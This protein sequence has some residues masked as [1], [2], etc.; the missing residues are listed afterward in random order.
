V[1]RVLFSGLI[2]DSKLESAWGGYHHGQPAGFFKAVTI[3][4]FLCI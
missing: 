4:L 1:I 3:N 2:G